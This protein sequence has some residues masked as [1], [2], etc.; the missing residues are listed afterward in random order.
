MNMKTTLAGIG[1]ILAAVGFALKAIFD[2]DPTTNVDI[3]ATIAAV[4]AGIGLI[5]AKDAKDSKTVLSD[6]PVESTEPKA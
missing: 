1:S 3:G 4:T 2:A 5:A 6:K